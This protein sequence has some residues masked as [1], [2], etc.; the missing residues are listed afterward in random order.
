M[1][2]GGMDK[3]IAIKHGFKKSILRYKIVSE[4]QSGVFSLVLPPVLA[5]EWGVGKERGFLVPYKKVE[6][7]LKVSA[8]AQVCSNAM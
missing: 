4:N 1:E 2:T 5:Q 3:A 7:Q 6:N 8:L